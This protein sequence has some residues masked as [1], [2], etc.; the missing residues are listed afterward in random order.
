MNCNYEGVEI[1]ISLI[2]L[3]VGYKKQNDTLINIINKSKS[4][5]LILLDEVKKLKFKNF[6][7]K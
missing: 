3:L 5:N 6:K 4:E 7:I 1:P 2:K